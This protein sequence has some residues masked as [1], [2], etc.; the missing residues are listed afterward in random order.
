MSLS[1]QNQLVI[2]VLMSTYVQH[3][4]MG[5]MVHREFSVFN[6]DT[7]ITVFCVDACTLK[8]INRLE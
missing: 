5:D 7:Q 6:R 1:L 8:V 4:E 2:A 3:T